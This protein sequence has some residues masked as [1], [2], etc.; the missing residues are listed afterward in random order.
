VDESMIFGYFRAFW[1]SNVAKLRPW[2]SLLRV[3]ISFEDDG[4]IFFF[5]SMGV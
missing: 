2:R 4:A 5:F 3:K 1:I